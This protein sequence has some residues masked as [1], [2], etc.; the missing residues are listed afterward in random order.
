MNT[1]YYVNLG[2]H[3]P[4]AIAPD[5][6]QTH[7][8][9]L[10]QLLR[11]ESSFSQVDHAAERL[12][13]KS[14]IVKSDLDD[15]EYEEDFESTP[16]DA[17]AGAIA[18]LNLKGPIVKN[19]QYCGPRGTV[20]IAAELKKIY[21]N[22]NFIGAVIDLDSG[23]GQAYAVKPL[24]DV[25][26]ER[27]K[28]VV[29]LAGNLLCSAGYYIAAYGDEI[30]CDH[31]RSIIGCIGVMQSMVNTKPA[32]E[33]LG[34]EFHDVYATQSPLK[35]KTF[36]DALSGDYAKLKS[37]LLDPLAEDF[38]NDVKAQRPGI[39][40]DKTIFQGETFL[41][42][43][44]LDLGMIDHL[45]NKDFAISRVKALS[46]NYK[47]PKAQNQNSNMKNFLNVAALATLAAAPTTEQLDLANADLT[48]AGITKATLVSE[49][50]ITE[51]ANTATELEEVKTSLQTET[52]AKTQATNDH[53]AEIVAHNKTKE[54]LAEALS[55][56]GK[57][58]GATHKP[59]ASSETND[60]PPAA[61][62]E[63]DTEALLAA[64]PHNQAADKITG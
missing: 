47:A 10:A 24:T 8:P 40:N 58:P 59:G 13:S 36:A 38:H 5:Y 3:E 39:S 60:V 32:L 46:K 30:V 11:G 61:E 21:A 31:P 33:K 19:S 52:A 4:W 15:D 22:P 49:D 16:D 23:G 20:E 56:V 50:F 42:S 41:A 53:A 44:A 1:N 57:G 18:V 64:M 6:A 17:P 37:D 34:V 7:L 43:K 29:I 62:E 27:N 9:L 48:V 45:G 25:L 28:P 14:Y 12:K 55:K 26:E 63:D 2:L 51:A 54:A 35:N